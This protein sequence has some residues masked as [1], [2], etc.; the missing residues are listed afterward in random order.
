M[1]LVLVLDDE[2]YWQGLILKALDGVGIRVHA[3]GEG[4]DLLE[5]L[6]G[7]ESDLKGVL[8][9]GTLYGEDGR[10]E[11]SMQGW[12]I[13]RVVHHTLPHLK[14]IWISASEIPAHI[15]DVVKDHYP[16]RELV[17]NKAKAL[18]LAQKVAIL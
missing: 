4:A 12:E 6:P 7:Y 13:A 9:D 2:E 14:L 11:Q 8:I 5:A 18:E 17:E 15:A 10:R 16:K 3:F 1:A